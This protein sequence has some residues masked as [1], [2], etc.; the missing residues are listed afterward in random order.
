MNYA[1][2][3][4]GGSGTRLWPMS[5][6]NRPKQLLPLVA[7]QS[8]LELSLDRLAAVF[9]P[10]RTLI[11]TSAD[12]APAA[13]SAVGPRLPEANIVGEPCPRDTSNAVG[14]AC[15]LL[16]RR[17]PDARLGIFTAD[18]VI[19][20]ID[21][22]AA[23][24][25][26]AL[27]L[28]NRQPTAMITL[29]V[30]P[31]WP[32]TGLGYIHRGDP[33]GPR[34][35]RVRRFVEKPD[36]ATAEQYVAGG[37]YYWNSGMFIWRADTVINT[38]A[39]LRPDHAALLAGA[40]DAFLSGGPRAVELYAALPKIS[41]DYALMEPASVDSGCQVVVRELD[42]QWIDVGS[43]PVLADVNSVDGSNNLKVG[44]VATLDAA[45]NI[46]IN[47]SA[48]HVLAVAGLED[49]VIVHTADATLVVP[50]AR[51]QDLKKLLEQVRA[52]FG[53]RYE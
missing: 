25:R 21:R 26:D 4:A 33:I 1:V 38:L 41:I 13:R 12:L 15:Q 6:R 18:H 16:H 10:E 23:A 35:H 42:C 34:F 44:R 47:E 11:V 2:I 45:G 30:L 27:D 7:G 51:A 39:R 46:L 20:P 37:E 24:V 40:T 28:L 14:F 50:K 22:F 3:L 53:D 8:L 36:R 49:M 48:E 31:T 17:D 32:H 52:A 19:R 43:W 9:P 5:R 29:G